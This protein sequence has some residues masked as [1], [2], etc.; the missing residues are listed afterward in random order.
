MFGSGIAGSVRFSI[1]T[2]GAYSIAASATNPANI[3]EAYAL[4]ACAS[5]MLIPNVPSISKS[6]M[7]IKKGRRIGGPKNGFAKRYDAR[8]GAGV[9][10]GG[11][12]TGVVTSV[13]GPDPGAM[14][15]V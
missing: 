3:L 2:I 11:C 15:I 14:V 12:A 4:S 6:A 8:S 9:G 13:D 1:A 5:S 10:T 7:R